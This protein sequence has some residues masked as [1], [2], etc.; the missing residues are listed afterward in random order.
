MNFNKIQRTKDQ[1]SFVR[2]RIDL[3]PPVYAQFQLP[4]HNRYQAKMLFI[5]NLRYMEHLMVL[6]LGPIYVVCIIQRTFIKWQISYI[7]NT[8]SPCSVA[9]RFKLVWLNLSAL[10]PITYKSI[11]EFWCNIKGVYSYYNLKVDKVWRK[12]GSKNYTSFY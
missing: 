1:K 2:L 11:L 9:T 12:L 7:S 4:V 6:T 8:C 5:V 10:F 3:V